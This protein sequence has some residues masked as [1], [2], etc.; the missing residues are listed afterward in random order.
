[1]FWLVN[2][3]SDNGYSTYIVKADT[4]ESALERV[5]NS[6][7]YHSGYESIV[8]YCPIEFDD[9]RVNLVAYHSKAYAF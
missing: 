2:S 9:N 5:K 3:E 7:D 4:F 6:K 1:M 8:D